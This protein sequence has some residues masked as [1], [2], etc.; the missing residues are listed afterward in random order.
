MK[1]Y[2]MR[3]CEYGYDVVT[4][5]G[6]IVGFVLD[7]PDNEWHQVVIDLIFNARHYIASEWHGEYAYCFP[8][9]LVIEV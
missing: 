8:P 3:S 1:F 7:C 5:D 6:R 4:P 2:V 9:R